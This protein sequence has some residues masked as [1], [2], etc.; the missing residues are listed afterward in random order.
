MLHPNIWR[1]SWSSHANLVI[2]RNWWSYLNEQWIVFK[3]TLQIQTPCFNLLYVITRH[4]WSVWMCI[5]HTRR[6]LCHIS[7]YSQYRQ[8]ILERSAFIQPAVMPSADM[9]LASSHAPCQVTLVCP[10]K[11]AELCIEPLGTVG[12]A[13]K[14]HSHIFVSIPNLPEIDHPTTLT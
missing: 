11:E 7:H 4:C 1:L 10:N 8:V 12:I 9:D 6:I 13:V 14:R 2:T 5:V 3:K